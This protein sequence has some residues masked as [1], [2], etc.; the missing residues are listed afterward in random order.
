MLID[1]IA[2]RHQRERG[3]AGN[4]KMKRDLDVVAKRR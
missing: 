1:V 3:A 2:G 4:G